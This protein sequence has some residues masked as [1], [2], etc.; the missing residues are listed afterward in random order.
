M[1]RQYSIFPS[2]KFDEKTSN[3]RE[4]EFGFGKISRYLWNKNLDKYILP[5]FRNEEYW[6]LGIQYPPTKSGEIGD[7]QIGC[8]GSPFLDELDED[9]ANRE[10]GEELG[11]TLINP[12]DIKFHRYYTRYFRNT[13]ITHHVYVYDVSNVDSITVSQRNEPKQDDKKRKVFVIINGHKNNII[14]LMERLETVN[15]SKDFPWAVVAIPNDFALECINII[16]RENV[17][18][19]IPLEW[20]NLPRFEDFVN[21]YSKK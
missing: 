21:K 11:L 13:T 20:Y 17:D 6:T 14:R 8:S 10:I 7:I 1:N 16:R 9:C 19:N 12:R 15:Q 2:R 3:F 18:V 5:F 4:L